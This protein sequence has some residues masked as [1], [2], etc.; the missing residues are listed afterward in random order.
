ML[1]LTARYADMW[2]T[3]YLGK[4]ETFQQP[5]SDMLAACEAV[6]RDPNSLQMT[7]LATL[8]Y[9]DLGM[10]PNAEGSYLTGT[11]EEV[12]HALQGYESMGAAHVIFHMIPYRQEAF[13]RAARI[14]EVY[15][16]NVS[17]GKH[18]L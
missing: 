17:G 10:P 15:K 6:G 1:R 4:P 11:A 5:R 8:G 18:A 7:V 13:E 16:M 9:P 3:G 14:V 12:V 2:N